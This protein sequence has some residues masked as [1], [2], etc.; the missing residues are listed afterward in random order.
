MINVL[1]SHLSEYYMYH[2]T[3]TVM[4]NWTRNHSTSM[5]SRL[6]YF[7]CIHLLSN[8]DGMIYNLEKMSLSF[9][10]LPNFYNLSGLDKMLNFTDSCNFIQIYLSFNSKLSTTYFGRLTSLISM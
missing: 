5:Y 7:S 8:F 2:L 3:L 10:E 4:T 9:I 6:N 1:L